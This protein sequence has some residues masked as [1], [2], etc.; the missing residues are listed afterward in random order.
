L[1]HNQQSMEI[2]SV[3]LEPKVVRIDA[4][5]LGALRSAA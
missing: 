3:G 5:G 2:H 4:G 1:N